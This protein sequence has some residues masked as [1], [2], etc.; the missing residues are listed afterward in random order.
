MQSAR[1]KTTSVKVTWQR[2]ETVNLHM[3]WADRYFTVISVFS[4]FLLFFFFLHEVSVRWNLSTECSRSGVAAAGN[5]RV[6]IKWLIRSQTVDTVMMALWSALM[7]AGCHKSGG[8]DEPDWSICTLSSSPIS[9]SLKGKSG[10]DEWIIDYVS[11][12]MN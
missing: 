2:N 9:H 6:D 3:N 11:P 12:W 7:H 5:C 4:D 1:N 10:A 8:E